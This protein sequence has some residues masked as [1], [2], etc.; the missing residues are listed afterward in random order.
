MLVAVIAALA[1]PFAAASSSA[2]QQPN[3][4]H[5]AIGKTVVG[6]GTGPYEVNVICIALA[7]LQDNELTSA[8]AGVTLTFDAQGHPVSAS[9]VFVIEGD[10]FVYDTFLSG[11]ADCTVQE[12]VTGGASSTGWSCAYSATQIP[13]AQA[14]AGGCTAASGTGTGP[15]LFHYEGPATTSDETT[16]IEFTNT[17]TVAPP[18]VQAVVV[19]PAF[20]G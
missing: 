11:P 19:Q 12:T 14:T 15:I 7:P 1:I 13:Q 18:V 9:E 4:F 2:Q 5:L 6:T 17:F 8:A 20:T 3:N 16:Q 10:Q